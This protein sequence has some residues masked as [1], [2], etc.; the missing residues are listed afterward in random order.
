MPPETNLSSDATSQTDAK[1]KKQQLLVVVLLAGLLIAILTQ[2]KKQQDA[3]A[4]VDLAIKA[5]AIQ[6][7]S[8]SPKIHLNP[9]YLL[10]RDL[11]RLP[12]ETASTADLFFDP[13]EP[14]IAEAFVDPESDE[15]VRRERVVAIYGTKSTQHS[16][17][18]G[19]KIV[20]S[21]ESLSDGRKVLNVAP[22]GVRLSPP[23]A[24]KP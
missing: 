20:R 1:K 13:P 8:E 5:D 7:V 21:G 3:D 17:L 24:A 10:S 15:P 11:S 6:A 16:A 9:K 12:T 4:N 2:P 18:V 22:E 14:Q 19:N 23:Q